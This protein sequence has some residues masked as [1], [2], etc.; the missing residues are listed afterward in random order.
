MAPTLDEFKERAEPFDHVWTVLDG[1]FAQL[2][3]FVRAA[4][5]VMVLLDARTMEIAHLTIGVGSPA[6]IEEQVANIRA[7]PPAY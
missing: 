6:S 2:S 4:L 7:R 5:P 3:H 1:S